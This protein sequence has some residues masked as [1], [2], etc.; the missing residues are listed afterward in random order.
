M[1][2]ATPQHA[3]YRDRRAAGRLWIGVAGYARKGNVETDTSLRNSYE[4]NLS[5]N[6]TKEVGRNLKVSQNTSK[7]TV[8]HH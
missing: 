2:N 1:N 7:Q 5:T 3:A 6:Q 8:N 4:V